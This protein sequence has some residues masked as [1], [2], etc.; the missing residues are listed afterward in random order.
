VS[1]QRFDQLLD[2]ETVVLCPL[3]F[4]HVYSYNIIVHNSIGTFNAE[5]VEQE[6]KEA[7]M[8]AQYQILDL[9]KRRKETEK[10]MQ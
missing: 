10:G 4:K 2:E 7:E 3:R 6:I 8:R 5:T 9:K 1:L